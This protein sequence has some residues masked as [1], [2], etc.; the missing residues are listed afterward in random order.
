MMTSFQDA[1][2]DNQY[3]DFDEVNDLDFMIKIL[4]KRSEP[5]E[6]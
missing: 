2:R 4:S 3:N 5:A 1:F 6:K